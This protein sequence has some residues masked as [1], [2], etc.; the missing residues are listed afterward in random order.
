MKP[1]FIREMKEGMALYYGKIKDYLLY[2]SL[3]HIYMFV[4][5][6]IN[7]LYPLITME[8]FNGTPMYI[9]ITEIAYASGMLIGGLLLGLFGNYQKRILLITASIFMMGISLTISGLLPQS[10]FFIFVVCWQ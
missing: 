2:Y 4:Y 7:A 5:M 9:S 8:Y 1:N 3:E 6:P 10:G